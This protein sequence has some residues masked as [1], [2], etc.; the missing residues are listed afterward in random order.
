MP[1]LERISIPL[2]KGRT[3]AFLPKHNLAGILV[4]PIGQYPYAT[5]DSGLIQEALDH[6]IDSPSLEALTRKKKSMVIVTSDHTRA[7]P[8]KSTLPILL[9]RI[10]K[11]NPRIQITI[12]V[13]TGGHRAMTASELREKFGEEIVCRET[14]IQHS[15]Y[16]QESL[17]RIATL[18]SGNELWINRLAA[19]TELLV[20]EGLIEP[21]FFAGFS[22]GRKSILPGIAGYQSIMANHCAEFVQHEY[23]RTGNLDGNPVHRDMLEAAKLAKL[24]FILNVVLRDDGNI[25]KAYSGNL[26]TA[27]EQ[28]V[29]FLREWFTVPRMIGD[30]V[31][32]SNGG[33]P[34]DRNIYQA[35]KG[36]STAESCCKPNGVIIIVAA[37]Q[38][39]HGGDSFFQML[40][41]SETPADLHRRTC[42]VP[43][44]QTIPDQ[45][46]FQILSRILAY[47]RV[48]L[49]TPY[50]DPKIIRAMQLEHSFTLEEA[51]GMAL[52]MQGKDARIVV[53]PNGVS[54]MVED[55]RFEREPIKES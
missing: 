34:L 8:S 16:D 37:C 2:A 20:A 46:E 35:V 48:I 14:L 17:V 39:G 4:P 52:Q 6:P 5:D 24:A 13:G 9:H 25:I 36:M 38:D 31:I 3:D 18:P 27:H 33:Y 51:V 15:A 30:I 49:V 50:C 44:D 28:G 23:A 7:M 45:W 55:D 19:E 21:H 1:E 53:I 43:R 26:Q 40:S 47:H 11:A 22:G 29:Q 10:R 42:R 41:S 12:L 32:T 54:T